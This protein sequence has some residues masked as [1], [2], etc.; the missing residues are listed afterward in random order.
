MCFG[1]EEILNMGHNW[2][3]GLAKSWPNPVLY[4]TCN[5]Q[6]SVFPALEVSWTSSQDLPELI[7]MYLNGG[8][9]TCAVHMD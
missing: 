2:K 1:A 8:K 3:T 6:F 5:A 7:R 4:F 9:W